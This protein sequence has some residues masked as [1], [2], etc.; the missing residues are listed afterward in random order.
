MDGGIVRRCAAVGA[1][2]SLWLM[3]SAGFVLAVGA[4]VLAPS[5]AEA[6][7]CGGYSGCNRIHCNCG[8]TVVHSYTLNSTA[9]PN[10]NVVGGVL[11]CSASGAAF[12]LKVASSNCP[13]PSTSWTCTSS[14]C[15]GG[16]NDGQACANNAACRPAGAWTCNAGTCTDGPN[17]GS[18]CK[19]NLD[20]QVAT[21]TNN[22]CIAGTD[23]GSPCGV[24]FDGG[25]VV[26]QGPALPN[27]KQ[28]IQLF[29]TFGATVQNAKV[30]KWQ[31][32]IQLT[33]FARRN[34]VQDSE[35]Y[36]N[37]TPGLHN[38]HYG[39]DVRR[40]S[41]SNI[42][43]RLTV[44]DNGDEGVHISSQSNNNVLRLSTL[45]DNGD[46]PGTDGEQIYLLE[47]VGTTIATNTAS[48]AVALRSE[49]SDNG[50]ISRNTFTGVTELIGDSTGNTLTNNTINGRLRFAQG[51][52]GNP[53]GNTATVT[54]TTDKIDV[55][56]LACIEFDRSYGNTIDIPAA[57]ITSC[58]AFAQT[59]GQCDGGTTCNVSGDCGC[60]GSCQV[61]PNLCNS[62]SDCNSCT[63]GHCA[64]APLTS[65]GGTSPCPKCDRAGNAGVCGSDSGPA[66][67]GTAC[68]TVSNC[69]CNPKTVYSCVA[70]HC[71]GGPANGQSC[72]E[73]SVC[74]HNT[75]KYC[76]T[77]SAPSM[78]SFAPASPPADP[79]I[80]IVAGTNC[81]S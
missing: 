53:T 16:P 70:S 77:G 33:D 79:A 41:T 13:Y 44:H 52:G 32:G 24:V 30:T 42:L 72:T 35:A 80:D 37:G 48:G 73:D 75:F 36:G 9:E 59:V 23:A 38:I 63:M 76:S 78:S 3:I 50:N 4:P 25:N 64:L 74:N 7:N 62:D 39:I 26:I 69:P 31:Q 27:I 67:G 2:V 81:P 8:D 29:G 40:D 18:A 10:P 54:N 1:R 51:T 58:A 47:V 34:V 17:G 22:V 5:K 15:V 56:S 19:D 46:P 20:C 68:T 65:C 28:G 49:D 60:W 57:Q 71:A 66:S 21:C 55:S 61:T 6:A 14:L 12:G 11:D 43:R 45:T